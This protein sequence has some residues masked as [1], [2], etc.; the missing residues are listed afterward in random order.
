MNGK[1]LPST[2]LC[3][4]YSLNVEK[5][6]LFMKKN[7]TKHKD[8]PAEVQNYKNTLWKTR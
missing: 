3:T 5:K 8:N 1:D 4:H 6:G 2:S 7:K